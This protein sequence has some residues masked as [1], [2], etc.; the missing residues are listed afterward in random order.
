MLNE[1]VVKDG[2][3]LMCARSVSSLCELDG[4]C[5][6]G[7][8]EGELFVFVD[9]DADGVGCVNCGMLCGSMFVDSTDGVD[10]GDVDVVCEQKER[11]FHETEH[12]Y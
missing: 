6:C 3:G 10:I 5:R 11:C 12:V 2:V 9:V 7:F 8:S 1:G 4:V